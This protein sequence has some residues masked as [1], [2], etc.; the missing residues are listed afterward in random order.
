MMGDRALE[1]AEVY[2]VAD[3]RTNSVIV[4]AS[5]DTLE[6]I[7]KVIEKHDED[8]A[9]VPKIY[10]Y[11]IQHADLEALKEI[12]ENMFED[13]SESSGVY[14]TSGS[15]GS[16]GGS[17]GGGGGSSRGGGG[18]SGGGGSSGGGGGGGR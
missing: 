18:G 11:R 2:I 16:A 17:R 12:L 9:S 1:E 3:V 6:E 5:A 4:R 7:T 15:G 10:V 8:P 14:T 13:L